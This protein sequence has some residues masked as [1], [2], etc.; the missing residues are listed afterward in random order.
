MISDSCADT[1]RKVLI[2]RVG[3]NLLPSAQSGRLRPAGPCGSG[4]TRRKQ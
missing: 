2:K 3:E 1:N 4:S